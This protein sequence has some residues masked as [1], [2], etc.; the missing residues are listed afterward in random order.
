MIITEMTEA[1]RAVWDAYVRSSAGGLPYHLSGWRQVLAKTYGYETHFM[2]ATEEGHLVG[3]LPLFIIRSFLVGSRAT[4]MLG[5]LCAENADVAQALIAQ[6]KEVAGQA[7]VKQLVLQDVR[8]P[9]P[10]DLR[11]TTDHVHWIIDMH[12]GSDALRRP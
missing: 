3:V 9:W 2:M 6:G 11:T 1:D 4:T 12:P 5:G 10:G 7:K 8:R